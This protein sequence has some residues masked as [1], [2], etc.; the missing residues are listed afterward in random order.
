MSD[1]AE[2][3]SP[4]ET[5]ALAAHSLPFIAWLVLAVLLGEATGW[6]YAVRGVVCLALFLYFRP[7]RWYPRFQ[8]KN[9]LPALLIG[10][11]V[12]MIW[13]FFETDFAARWPGLQELYYTVGIMPPW[14]ITYFSTAS[15]YA[16]QVCGW[17][18]TIL[19]IL[20]SA[21]V[22]S[23]IEEFFWRGCIYR[24]LIKKDFLSVDPARFHAGLFLLVAL[25]FGVEHSRWLVG[26]ITGILYG[27]LYLRT[28]DIW[29]AGI[30][31][32]MTNLLLGIYVVWANKYY[33]W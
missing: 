19:K 13:I 4:S 30:A 26:F 1:S 31:H 24:W 10:V 32:A 28:R 5:T 20:A 15:P 11:A 16:P 3:S 18:F 7:W 22:I 12:F 14:K 2:S 29:A 8:P 33:F 25:G 21:F 27:W 6:K 23:F 17:T 9:L